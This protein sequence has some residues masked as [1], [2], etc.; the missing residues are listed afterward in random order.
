VNL[1]VLLFQSTQRI[2]LDTFEVDED[3]VR[4]HASSVFTANV[5]G[6]RRAPLLRAS[7]CA[8]LLDLALCRPRE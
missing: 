7:V 1:E 4:S 2:W 8:A 3:V 6:H 5:S